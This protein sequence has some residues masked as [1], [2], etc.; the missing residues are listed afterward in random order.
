MRRVTTINLN[1]HALQIEEDGY[2][3]LRAWLDQAARALARNPDRTRILAELEQAIA[4]KCQQQL[5]S[6]RNVVGAEQI[7]RILEEMGPVA[8]GSGAAAPGMAGAAERTDAGAG[9]ASPGSTATTTKAPRRLYRLDEGRMVAG[10]CAGVAAWAG[11]DATWVRVAVVLLTVFSGGLGLI[12]YLALVLVMPV[13]RTAEELSAAHGQPF[14]AQEVV[15]RASSRHEEHRSEPGARHEAR[16][17]GPWS[18]GA[19]T[20]AMRPAPGYAARVTG[21]VLLPVL[22]LLS[23]AWFSALAITLLVLWW[24]SSYVSLTVW[25]PGEWMAIPHL[26]QWVAMLAVLVVYVLIALPIGAGR[27]AAL[28]YTN[29]GRAYGWANAWSGLLWLA[30]VG[31][32]LLAAWL[33]LPMFQEVLHGLFGWPVGRGFGATWV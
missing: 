23:A 1:S 17:H 20:A 13:A 4:E 12:A 30:V 10:V 28:Y 19:G 7:N 3:A 22:T 8:D 2:E 18:G 6:H 31:L 32:V 16:S 5:G 33:A 25:P 26:P 24:S 27:R 15:D 29:G 11:M 14:N 21:G 9:G